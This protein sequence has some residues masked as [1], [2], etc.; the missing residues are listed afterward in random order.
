TQ[1]VTVS[2]G[3]PTRALLLQ[4]AAGARS[5]D[6]LSTQPNIGLV[7]SGGNRVAR[8]G[9]T[10]SASI[11][12]GGSLGGTTSLT[13]DANGEVLYTDLVVNGIMGTQY[14]LTFAADDN[15]RSLT[16]ATQTIRAQL[17]SAAQIA[18]VNTPTGTQSGVAFTTAPVIEIQDAGGNVIADS[19]A[20]ISASVTKTDGSAGGSLEGT[21]TRNAVGGVATFADLGITG[22]AGQS[23]RITFSSGSYTSA[24]HDVTVSVGPASSLVITSA[25]PVAS[26]GVAF[27]PSVHAAGQ[28]VE[29]A[30]AS[31]P[32][33]HQVLRPGYRLGE[34]VLRA[35]M[36]VVAQR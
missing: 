9:V 12:T 20:A 6:V 34:R 17:G 36:V 19:S 24:H 15:G 16:S 21:T 33:V 11:S 22:V 18:L 8:S 35:A 26:A 13:T 4:A 28:Q 1:D 10:V 5:G 2:T 29:D 7:D 27:D 14:T 25:T 30:D 3:D 32:T 23:Y 31:E